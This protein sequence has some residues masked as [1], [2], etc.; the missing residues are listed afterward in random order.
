MIF[1]PNVSLQNFRTSIEVFVAIFKYSY[2]FE[3]FFVCFS[4]VL[5]V[6]VRV[7]LNGLLLVTRMTFNKLSGRLW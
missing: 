4:C 7:V 1:L 3:F 2:H 5:V 6:W